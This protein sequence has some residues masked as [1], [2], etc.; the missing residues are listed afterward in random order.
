MFLLTLECK[1][2]KIKINNN[3]INLSELSL[4]NLHSHLIKMFYFFPII[5]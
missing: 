3:I 4:N 2:I 5:N 1:K